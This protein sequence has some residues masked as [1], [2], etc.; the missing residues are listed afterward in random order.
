MFLN[1]FLRYFPCYHNAQ[2]PMHY[3]CS[4]FSGNYYYSC[5]IHFLMAQSVYFLCFK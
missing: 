4:V 2:L 1:M 5:N 3:K